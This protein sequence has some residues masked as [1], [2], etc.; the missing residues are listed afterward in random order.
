MSQ[1][2]FVH[3]DQIKRSLGP[4]LLPMKAVSLSSTSQESNFKYPTWT[5]VGGLPTKVVADGISTAMVIDHNQCVFVTK[6][7]TNGEENFQQVGV[8]SY[9]ISDAKWKHITYYKKR[10]AKNVLYIRWI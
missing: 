6:L 7:N 10:F 5:L 8:W 4:F 9:N 3:C 2:T 1:L